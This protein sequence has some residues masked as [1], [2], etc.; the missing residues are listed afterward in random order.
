MNFCIRLLL[1]L[2]VVAVISQG[3]SK[4]ADPV[5]PDEE[6]VDDDTITFPYIMFGSE[7]K[8]SARIFS[9][10]REILDSAHAGVFVAE[11]ALNYFNNAQPPV[12]I[13]FESKDTLAIFFTDYPTKYGIR[14]EGNIDYLYNQYPMGI[15]SKEDTSLVAY[16]INPQ[17]G[18]AH[19]V[20]T[21]YGDYKEYIIPVFAYVRLRYNVDPYDSTKTYQS[22]GVMGWKYSVFKE[23]YVQSLSPRDTFAIQE[24]EIVYKKR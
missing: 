1:T 16:T 24:Y 7:Q 19:E 22:G 18:Y 12:K 20:L 10:G 4:N 6:T 11:A 5:P 21:G 8:R 3:C 13:Q 15:L 14:K 2:V 23:S 17:T 9:N